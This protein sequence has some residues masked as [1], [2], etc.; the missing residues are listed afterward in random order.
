MIVSIHWGG[1]WGY[2]VP[3]D[4][5]GFARRLV[6]Q[7]AADVIHGHSSH[8]PKGI[9][10]HR[11]KLILYGCGDLI[12]DYEGIGGREEYRGNLSLLYF[13]GVRTSDG[14]LLSLRMTPFEIRRF[15]LNN[16]SKRDAEWLRATLDRES[17]A[18][19]ARRG[20]RRRRRV[21]SSPAARDLAC[22]SPHVASER[23]VRGLSARGAPHFR[24]RRRRVQA[25]SR[26]TSSTVDKHNDGM[27]G[28]SRACSVKVG[29]K[30]RLGLEQYYCPIVALTS[31][32]IYLGRALVGHRRGGVFVLADA[33]SA[34]AAPGRDF[35]GFDHRS[36]ETCRTRVGDGLDRPWGGCT[37]GGRL[38][39]AAD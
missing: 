9:E 13:A 26:G 34:A 29:R 7:G 31:L 23:R 6:D 5:Q 20:D 3:D 37:L 38:V 21:E 17:P 16:A 22:I 28:L 8:H 2:E 36:R 4:Q 35:G 39:A 33:L 32:P 10:V 24:V 19:R 1:N 12:N 30:C 25:Y 18:L 11:G 15:R 27:T 14:A